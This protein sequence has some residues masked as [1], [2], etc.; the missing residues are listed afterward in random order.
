MTRL[1]I[2]LCGV[3]K[4][5]GSQSA[6][7]NV[8]LSIAAGRHTAILGP[9]GS[10][11][12]TLL[13][14]I[15]GLDCPSAGSIMIDGRLVARAGRTVA[16]PHERRLALVFQDLALWP[17]LTVEQNVRLGLAGQRLPRDEAR[18]RVGSALSACRI[19]NLG[20]RRPAET[21]GGEQQRTAL[22]R[23][24]AVHPR[25]LLLDEPFSGVDLATKQ[26]ILSE[27][28][29]LAA[30]HEATI[31]LVTHD[32]AE[33]VVLCSHAFTL[34]DHRLGDCGPLPELIRSSTAPTLAAFRNTIERLTP[35][36][37]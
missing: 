12:S 8:S 32:P 29:R 5:F 22:A 11:K 25:Y 24:L 28:A 30:E 21:S 4:A 26:A 31:V 23:A 16:P 7:T 10:G 33:A 20:K 1:A 3:S 27:I 14:L 17:N 19:E 2:E 37:E 15:A 34:E 13:R 35:R 9:S 18:R 36:P 6:L